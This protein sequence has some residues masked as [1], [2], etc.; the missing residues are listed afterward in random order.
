MVILCKQE[1]K[2]AYASVCGFRV[3]YDAYRMDLESTNGEAAAPNSEDTQKSYTKHKENYENLR[4]VVA[5]KLQFLDENRV[6]QSCEIN[7]QF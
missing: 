2:D 5:V 6:I 3:E 7:Q 4:S 1:T